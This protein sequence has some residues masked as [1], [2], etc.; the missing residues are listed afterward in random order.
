ML[1]II[2]TSYTCN[3]FCFKLS[4]NIQQ[5]TLYTAS[6]IKSYFTHETFSSE[7]ALNMRYNHLS[8]TNLSLYVSYYGRSLRMIN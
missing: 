1:I 6:F 7:E 4:I 2:V 5:M 3:T 8:R